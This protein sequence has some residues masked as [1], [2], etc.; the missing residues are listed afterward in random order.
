[1]KTR[2]VKIGK[3]TVKVMGVPDNVTDEEV[4]SYAVLQIKK[5]KNIGEVTKQNYAG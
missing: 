5:Q 4:Y 1:M 3:L 2:D